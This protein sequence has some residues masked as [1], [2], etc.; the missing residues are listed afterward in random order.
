MR[1]HTQEREEQGPTNKT[2]GGAGSVGGKAR[3]CRSGPQVH[4]RCDE[5]IIFPPPRKQTQPVYAPS[6]IQIGATGYMYPLHDISQT[7][8][9]VQKRGHEHFLFGKRSKLKSSRPEKPCCKK[10][11]QV[12]N[13]KSPTGSTC[14][15]AGADTAYRAP[16]FSAPL[17][18]L[19]YTH[20]S[21]K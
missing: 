4:C 13:S 6:Q 12:S 14:A 5:P 17:R 2:M 11:Q 10:T 1:Q 3:K 16:T 9:N 20:P 21:I 7:I 19:H 15:W 8:R 18:S